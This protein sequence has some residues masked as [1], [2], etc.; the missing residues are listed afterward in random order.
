MVT[1]YYFLGTSK[2]G[3]S[4]KEGKYGLL[5]HAPIPAVFS[6]FFYHFLSFT[7]FIFYF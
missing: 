2:S 6:L 1:S 7:L 3:F 4:K 5:M